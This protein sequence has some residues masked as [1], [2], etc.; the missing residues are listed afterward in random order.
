[1]DSNNICIPTTA[2]ITAIIRAPICSILAWLWLYF[3]LVPS[4]SLT[5]TMMPERV[6]TS[7]CN[8]SDIIAIEFDAMPIT[9]LKIASNRFTNIAI[10]PALSTVWEWLRAVILGAVI[11]YS[12]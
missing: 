4:F 12:F 9:T 6:S 3:W 11:Y 10:A 7:P 8:A 5:I 1:M 2:M